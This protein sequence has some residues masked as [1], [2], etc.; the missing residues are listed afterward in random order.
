MWGGGIDGE[1]LVPLMAVIRPGVLAGNWSGPCAAISYFRPTASR[2]PHIV[3]RA[4]TTPEALKLPHAG[5]PFV[6][7]I[8]GCQDFALFGT[9]RDPEDS[10][11][12]T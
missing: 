7:V 2:P 1:S 11:A 4:A 9:G 5:E 8:Q 6:F 3:R 10:E 12:C